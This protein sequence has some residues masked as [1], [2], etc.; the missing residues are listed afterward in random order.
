MKKGFTPEEAIF[1]IELEDPLGY[2]LV[3]RLQVK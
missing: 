3:L 1:M 2:P